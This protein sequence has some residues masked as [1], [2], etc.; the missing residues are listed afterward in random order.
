MLMA[1]HFAVSFSIESIINLWQRALPPYCSDGIMFRHHWTYRHFIKSLSCLAI[2]LLWWHSILT[3]FSLLQYLIFT[4]SLDSIT[5]RRYVDKVMSCKPFVLTALY[6]NT[7][8]SCICLVILLCSQCIILPYCLGRLSFTLIMSYCHYL[9]I[10]Y[11]DGVALLS[12]C[13]GGVVSYCYSVWLALCLAIISF[14][15]IL[16][17]N[18]FIA[19]NLRSYLIS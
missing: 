18:K 14:A 3:V 2:I 11:L 1:I 5:C 17:V 13:F 7:I 8:L 4:F 10:F 15:R 19:G 16:K 6:F 9:P 12:L